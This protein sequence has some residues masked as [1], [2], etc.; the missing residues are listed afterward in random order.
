MLGIRFSNDNESAK[1][2]FLQSVA[3]K[4]GTFK[5]KDEEIRQKDASN[6]GLF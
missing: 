2:G 4:P 6:T 1:L 5:P 3:K